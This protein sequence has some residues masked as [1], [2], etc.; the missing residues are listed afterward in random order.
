M[1]KIETLLEI[2]RGKYDTRKKLNRSGDEIPPDVIEQIEAGAVTSEMLAAFAKL[3]PVFIYKTCI[4]LHGLFSLASTPRIGG[5]SNLIQNKNGSLEVLYTAIDYAKKKRIGDIIALASDFIFFHDSRGSSYQTRQRLESRED[6]AKYKPEFEA[7]ADRIKAVEFYG[8]VDVYLAQSPFGGV[9]LVNEIS[10]QAIPAV[11]VEPMIEAITGQTMSQLQPLIDAA[12]ERKAQAARDHALEREIAAKQKAVRDAELDVLKAEIAHLP[13]FVP[14]V[15]SLGVDAVFI[16]S[17]TACGFRV[18]RITGKGAF[19]RL[20]IERTAVRSLD[21]L[22]RA[23]FRPIPKE[24]RPDD[25][26]L[27]GMKALAQIPQPAA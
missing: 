15:G 6:F 22:A 19:G 2:A 9:Y 24:L 26:M 4:T 10:I 5:Y 14:A 25:Y 17:G 18:F 16:N 21:R 20:K 12:A 7:L 13:A 1:K 8:R 3:F 11:S 27:K 23:E